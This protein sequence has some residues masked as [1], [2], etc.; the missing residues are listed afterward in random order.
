MNK[1]QV[2]VCIEGDYTV[3]AENEEEARVFASELAIDSDD[4]KYV[5]DKVA[6]NIDEY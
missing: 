3:V 5:V 2:Y 6:E 4:W 1:Y